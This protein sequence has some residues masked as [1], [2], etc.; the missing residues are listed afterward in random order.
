MGNSRKWTDSYER[1]RTMRPL[2]RGY[3]IRVLILQ[4]KKRVEV[5]VVMEWTQFSTTTYFT[6]K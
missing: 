3:V 2:T 6:N 4:V 1:P 5:A